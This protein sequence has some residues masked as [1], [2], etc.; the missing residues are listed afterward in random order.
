MKKNVLRKTPG[1]CWCVALL[2]TAFSPLAA[3]MTPGV[4]TAINPVTPHGAT[5]ATPTLTDDNRGDVA[6]IL[7]TLTAEVE[8][9]RA[10]LQALQAERQKPG[11][12]TGSAARAAPGE[13]AITAGGAG[14]TPAAA[15]LAATPALPVAH[16]GGTSTL[17]VSAAGATPALTGVGTGPILAP[18]GTD[19]VASRRAYASGVSLARELQQ[20]LT[21]Q[22]ALGIELSPDQVLAGLQDALTHKTLRLNDADIQTAMNDLNAD[23]ISRMKARR[24][25]EQAQGNAFRQAFRKQKGV[26]S[27][28]GSLYQFLN[29][30]QLPR[31]HASDLASLL[32]TA[33]LPDGTVFDPSGA[34]GE[35]KQARV[36]ALIPAVAIGLQKVGVGGHLIVVV[37]P[38]KA[39]GDMGAPPAIPGGAT[40]IFDITVKGVNQT[41]PA[42][43]T[44]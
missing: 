34:N 12:V 44:K 29:K 15:A 41:A 1:R 21:V 36:S 30:G 6:A 35:V 4:P 14:P 18:A 8:Q 26:V 13:R 7:A 27:D 40:V 39:Y 9:Q 10:L 20:S 28:A 33:R 42:V 31:L 38:N 3:E 37:P 43:L 22:K 25:D 19:D 24:D 17:S 5:D 2:L 32:I 11:E 23:F 16:G